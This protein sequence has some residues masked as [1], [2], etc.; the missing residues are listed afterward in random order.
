MKHKKN[1]I[2]HVAFSCDKKKQKLLIHALLKCTHVT[3]EDLAV[4]IQVPCNSLIA[5]YEGKDF[6]NKKY[7]KNLM[8][9]FLMLFSDSF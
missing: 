4:L 6:L 7:A 3:L 5:V 2:I 1:P 8:Y 9:L